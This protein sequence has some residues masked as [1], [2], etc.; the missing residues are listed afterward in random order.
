MKFGIFHE[1]SVAKPWHERSEYQV[2]HNA[3]EQIELA[4][5]E[6]VAALQEMP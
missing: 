5:G 2:Y 3:L 6:V 1:L 4:L